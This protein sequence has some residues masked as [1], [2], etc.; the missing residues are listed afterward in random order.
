MAQKKNLEGNPQNSNSFSVLPIEDLIIVTNNMGISI[1]KDNFAT[2]DLLKD[3]E[4]A[5]H[6]LF[7]RRDESEPTHQ[8]DPSME[9][10]ND[11][12]T[13]C[14]EWAHDEVSDVE[15]FILVESRKKREK[16]TKTFYSLLPLGEVGMYRKIMACP[17]KEGGGR[18]V[19]L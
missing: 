17:R 18:M 2:F 16:G 1:P 13:L 14:L 4:N 15:D 3:L 19:P 9:I 12:Q 10:P 6:D 8:S 11:G 5:R 7:K